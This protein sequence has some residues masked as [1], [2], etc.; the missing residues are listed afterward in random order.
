MKHILFL[1]RFS[2]TKLA[3]FEIKRAN[4]P[5]PFVFIYISHMVMK[6]ILLFLCLLTTAESFLG[7]IQSNERAMNGEMRIISKKKLCF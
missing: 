5:E 2:P 6:I 7:H 1:L 4:K 3:V